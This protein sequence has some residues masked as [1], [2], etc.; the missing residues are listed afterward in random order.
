MA[1]PGRYTYIERMDEMTEIP[2]ARADLP[3]EPSRLR[4]SSTKRLIGGVAGG[5]SERFELDANI[6]RVI[7]VVLACIWGLGV[8][9]Y[10]AMWVLIPRGS[11]SPEEESL[12]RAQKPEAT[13]RWPYVALAVGVIFVALIFSTTAGGTPRLGPG[14]AILW[15]LFLAVLAVLALRRPS[16]RWTFRRLVAMMFL[17]G[18]SFVILLSGLFLGVVGIIGVPMRGGSGQRLVQPTSLA[19]T[20]HSYLTE[21][22]KS[23]VDLTSVNFPAGGYLVS[24]SVAVGVLDVVVPANAIVDLRTHV[25][26]GTVSFVTPDGYSYSRFTSVPT[27]PSGAQGRASAPHLTIDAQVGIGEILVTRAIH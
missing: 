10:L 25:G 5:I 21:F 22:G 11:S 18:L 1:D 4:R 15:L 16:Q 26:I 14:F 2:E 20:G 27:S 19:M 8:A 6:V 24:A 17:M 13:S 7:F 9:I 12:R 23:T 3:E